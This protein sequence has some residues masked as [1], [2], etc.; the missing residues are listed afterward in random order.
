ML[1]GKRVDP[2]EEFISLVI[3]LA[4]ESIYKPL[5]ADQAAELARAFVQGD[6]DPCEA[7]LEEFM[8]IP[9]A[10]EMVR[11]WKGCGAG[12]CDSYSRYMDNFGWA[13]LVPIKALLGRPPE[14]AQAH[15]RMWEQTLRKEGIV[16][17]A[18]RRE[19]NDAEKYLQ[20]MILHATTDTVSRLSG[21][22]QPFAG[23][24]S[25][26]PGEIRTLLRDILDR[27]RRHPNQD[28]FVTKE[29][30]YLARGISRLI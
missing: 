27:A 18:I 8:L 30:N 10:Y 29:I 3:R 22:N 15:F 26:L 4:A 16:A 24:P 7:Y 21:I 12:T 14:L 11:N 23:S 2:V 5:T 20:H 9:L 13:S 19:F 28:P 17:D 25:P 1:F 6:Y